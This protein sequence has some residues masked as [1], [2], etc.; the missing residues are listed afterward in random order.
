MLWCRLVNRLHI[1]RIRFHEIAVHLV[2][3]P[4][5]D[6]GKACQAGRSWCSGSGI[7]G[8]QTPVAHHEARAAPCS[9]SDPMGSA[10]AGV[11]CLFRGSRTLE[12]NGCDPEAFY[13][14]ALSPSP[15]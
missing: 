14:S 12:Q 6:A 8:G 2:R 4:D 11:V 1:I 9:E 5:S 13:A 7:A 3:P 10:G 15:G